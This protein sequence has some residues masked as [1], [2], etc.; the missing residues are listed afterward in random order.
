VKVLSYRITQSFD[1]F[2]SVPIVIKQSVY[3]FQPSNVQQ[4]V[5]NSRVISFRNSHIIAD[6]VWNRKLISRVHSSPPPF[7][8]ILNNI[9]QL[10]RLLFFY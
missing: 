4:P 3:V 6:I 1:F 8:L 5:P 2:F 9:N 7:V 10:Y